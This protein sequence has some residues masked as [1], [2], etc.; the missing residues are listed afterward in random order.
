MMYWLVSIGLLGA[1]YAIRPSQTKEAF[2]RTRMMMGGMLHQIA[3]L[4]AGMSLV[5]AFLPMASITKFLGQGNQ[6]LAS[7][8]GAL[9]GSV[10]IIPAFVAFPLVGSLV[11]IGASIVPAAAFLTTLTMVGVMTYPIEK[12]AFGQQYALVR[13]GLSFLG[14]LLIAW[15][16]GVVL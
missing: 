16:M 6:A 7:I 4:L 3:W 2:S 13:N 14:A 9:V 11:K 5:L 15:L 12:K 8:V 1:T 10:T